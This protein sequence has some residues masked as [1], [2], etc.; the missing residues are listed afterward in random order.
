MVI[1]SDIRLGSRLKTLI[2]GLGCAL[3]MWN[4]IASSAHAEDQG[5]L[6]L[7]EENDGLLPDGRDRHYTQGAMITYLSPSV[8]PDDFAAHLFDGLSKALPIFRPGPDVLRKFDVVIGQ[9]IF[10]PQSYHDPV[11]DPRD[12]PFAGYLF[13]G[14]SLL[15]DTGGTMLENFE[16]L[17]GVVGP[18]ALAKEAQKTFH[19]IAGFN[20][21]NLDQGYRYQLRNEPG[22]MLTYERKWRAWQ[23][24]VAGVQMEVIP[25]AGLTAGNVMTYADVG[26]MARIGENL[27]VDY[28][29]ARIRPAI[30][31]TAWFDASR[32]SQNLGWYLFAGVQGRAVAHNIFLDG[33]TV[34]DSRS[35][36]KNIL[37]GDFSAGA[38]VF[39]RDW[40]KLDV[41]FTERTKEFATQHQADHFGNMNLSVRF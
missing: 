19:S 16:L 24:S 17:G 30:S 11:P 3:C 33:N 35:V 25:E 22:F 20:N 15:Q 39:W 2:S 36:H 13:T 9:S 27:D 29:I 6:T 28:G 5:R 8:R 26:A 14:G 41:S 21:K 4:G 23:S 10:T 31:G 18:D 7:T 1:R 37:V 32:L 40:M 34:A 12:R 38:S